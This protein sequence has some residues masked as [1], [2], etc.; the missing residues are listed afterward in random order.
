MTRSIVCGSSFSSDAE[1]GGVE[2]ADEP[3]GFVHHGRFEQHARDARG[4]DDLERSELDRVRDDVA[5][6][7]ARFD[8]NPGRLERIRVRPL[9][10]DTADP[11][12]S[13]PTSASFT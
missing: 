3:I 10:G 8:A 1:R 7:I 2:A 6:R 12:A 13:S 4:L 9:D 11:P 5:E